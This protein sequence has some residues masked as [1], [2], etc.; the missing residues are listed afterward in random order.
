MRKNGFLIYLL[1]SISLLFPYVANSQDREATLTIDLA[2]NMGELPYLFRAGVFNGNVIPKGHHLEKFIR[3]LKP[4][5]VEFYIAHPTIRPSRDINDLERLLS[6]WDM[7]A[8]KIA[9]AGGEVVIEIAAMPSWLTSNRSKKPVNPSIG[10]HTPIG[11]LSPPKDYNEWSKMVEVIVNHFNNKVGVKAKYTIWGEPDTVWWQGTEDEYFKLYKFAVLG[12]KRADKAAR[13]GGPAVSIWMGKREGS[14]TPLLY[15]F[16]KYAAQTELQELGLKRLP[17]DY[18]NWHQFN[19]NPLDPNSFGDPVRTIKGWLKEYG[20]PEDTEILIGEWIIWQYFGK[21]HGFS[22]EEHDNEINASYIIS[23]ILAMDEA[24]IGRHSYAYLIDSVSGREFVGDFGLYTKHG[25]IKASFNAFKALSMLDGNRL[26]VGNNDY[27]VRAIA[28]HKDGKISVLISNFVPW[29]KMLLSSA[30]R[31]LKGKG[32][33]KKEIKQYNISRKQIEDVLSGRASVDTLKV[34][35]VLKTDIEQVVSEIQRYQER[36]ETPLNIKLN[37]QGAPSGRY[38][39]EKYLIDSMHSNSYSLRDKIESAVS[40][41]D[42]REI[43]DWKGVKLDK[44]DE[45][46]ADTLESIDLGMLPPYSTV[47]IVLTPK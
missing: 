7:V 42:V 18:I 16:I 22:N 5:A 33:T 6:E 23:A 43:N 21:E 8:K 28:T 41:K 19:A 15:N 29:G 35:Q 17:I 25:V 12:A 2:K 38:R 37:I 32:Y 46:M 27:T 4:G 40:L 31:K 30:A 45:G 39:Y 20:Y 3:D 11:N 24:G 44:T 10:D 36:R 9:E 1:L 47:F 34:P 14:S 13:I 26:H